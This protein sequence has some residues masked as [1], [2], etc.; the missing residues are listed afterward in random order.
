MRAKLDEN[1]PV[2]AAELLRAAGW[3]CDTVHDEGLGGA[4]DPKVAAAC[5]VEGRVLFTLDLDFSDIRT[6]PP[7]EYVGIVVFRP[8]EPNRRMVLP[9]SVSYR[10][11]DASRTQPTAR[12]P[13]MSIMQVHELDLS[14]YGITVKTVHRNPSAAALYEHAIRYEP[15]SSIAD[16]GALV[17]YSGS[18]TGRSPRDKRVVRHADSE[19][20]VWWGPVNLPMDERVFHLNRERAVDY[21]NTVDRLYVVDAFAGWHPG[22]RLKIRVI[23][24]RPYHALFMHTM[25]IRPTDNELATFGE[26]DY[27][28]F[29]AGRFPA[30]RLTEGMTSTT[31]VALSFEER[32]M[33]ILGTEYAGEMKKGVFTIM[34]YLMPKRGLLS[35]HCS[36]TADAHQARSSVLF[37]LSGTGKTTLSADPKRR[38]IGDDEHVWGDDGIFNIEGGCYAKAIDLTPESEPDIFHALRFGSVLENVVFDDEGHHVDFH[39]T[40]ITQNTRGA[41]PIEFIR[42]AKVPCV[43]GHPTDIIFLT[44]DAFGVLPPVSKLTPEQAMY[45]FISG[46]TAKVAGTE[47]GVTE[48]SA[49]FSACFGAPF[50]VWHPAKYAELLADKLREHKVNVWLINTGWSGGSH[51]V[52]SRIKLEYTRAIVDAIHTGTLASAPTQPDPIFGIHVVMHVPHVPA[53][54]L[55]PEHTWADKKAFAETAAK[56]ARLFAENFT[57]FES[58]STPEVRA[59]GPKV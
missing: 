8:A 45:H 16:S 14:R 1:V 43:A 54:M 39:D 18:K 32:Q 35:M 38:L 48:P 44:C 41:Y 51:G 34:N 59:A 20:D 42:N 28:I 27:V 2:E 50:L 22:H 40:T 56:L 25:L 55:I 53:A 52:G 58:G 21:L 9:A 3:T 7:N 57:K 23:C 13:I 31:S 10:H 47:M 24:S 12:E 30:N 17:A 6:Y 33:V 29:N 46:Y 4:E 15:G 26:P 49:T 11:A 5:R 19:Q 36:A 37:G